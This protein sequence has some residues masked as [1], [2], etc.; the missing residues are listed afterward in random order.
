MQ[1]AD[2][3]R[4]LG[5]SVSLE[6]LHEALP[7]AQKLIILHRVSLESYA[8]HF[9]T[10]AKARGI[11]LIYD[12]DDLVF[13]PEGANY[14]AQSTKA[15]SYTSGW[16]PYADVMQGCDAVT[17]STDFL[18]SRVGSLNAN[19]FVVL[20]ALSDAYMNTAKV[21]AKE[22]HVTSSKY[23]TMA[24]LSG[25]HSHDADFAIIEDVLIEVLQKYSKLR[26]LLVGPLVISDKFLQ[27]GDRIVRQDFTPYVDFP[28][29]FREVDINLIPL[30]TDQ[31]FCNAKS[32]LKFIEAAACGVVSVASPT[33]PHKA[34]IEHGHNGFLATSDWDV[35]LTALVEDA[36]LRERL[37]FEARR[38]VE[39]HY[40]SKQRKEVWTKVI[41]SVTRNS[42]HK[43]VAPHSYLSSLLGLKIQMGRYMLRKWA[44][45]KRKRWLKN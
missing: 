43:T 5:Y 31:A 39:T 25:S 37:G 35:C 6:T 8:R 33:E 17:V 23:I 32:E 14:L 38:H 27:F 20:N 24:Y 44:I 1:P 36:A 34:A 3:L 18:A 40:T 41:S 16:K 2:V 13:D 26:L 42:T 30:E 28:N 7:V 29:L 10:C 19:T 9:I 15:K 21:V 11:P 22:R 12:T 45:E 4:G